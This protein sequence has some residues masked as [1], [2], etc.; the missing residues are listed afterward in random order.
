MSVD[1]PD[2]RLVVFG[3]RRASMHVPNATYRLMPR[4]RFIGRHLQWPAE[5]RA[6]KPDA[7]FG[8]AGVLPLSG[9]GCPSVITIHDLAI[10]R[11][12][13]WFPARQ[14]LSTRVVVPRSVLRADVVVAVSENTAADIVAIFG[15]DRSRIPVAPHRVAPKFP[16]MS[17]GERA[18]PR[19]EV[20]PHERGAGGKGL[21][22]VLE[23]TEFA[24]GMRHRGILRAAQFSWAR[25][26]RQT[27]RAIDD[28][29]TEGGAAGS[30]LA[31]PAERGACSPLL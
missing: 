23:V 10:Y 9:V 28:A 16:H 31:R 2:C 11:N 5:I 20:P 7:Y 22:R 21:E 15:I 3:P 26:A 19:I 14:P 17:A 24:A 25:A 4:T 8:P 1:R 29:I 12:A 27:W 13:R 30:G 6:L 18:E